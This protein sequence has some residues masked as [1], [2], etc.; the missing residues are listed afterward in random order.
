MSDVI[1]ECGMETEMQSIHPVPSIASTTYSTASSMSR[2]DSVFSTPNT[3]ATQ[4]TNAS[5]ISFTPQYTGSKTPLL[6]LQQALPQSFEDMYSPELMANPNLLIDGRPM[7]TRRALQDWELN[8]IRSLLIIERLRTEWN[9][10]IPIIYSPP[11]FKFDYL[12]LDAD[13]NTVIRVL[14]ESDIYK[15]AKL[16]VAFRIQTAKFT[17]NS[18]RMRHE[19]MLALSGF[20]ISNHPYLSKPEWRNVIE[21]FLLNLA[22]ESQCRSDFKKLCHELKKWKRQQS[23]QPVSMSSSKSVTKGSLLK[24]AILNDVSQSTL[25]PPQQVK[26]T[27]EEKAQ[28]WTEVQEKVYARIGLDWT[29]DRITT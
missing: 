4:Y 15:E 8:D 26:L 23:A 18:A 1:D 27:K 16:D 9:G 21:N 14:V 19:Q 5:D 20:P 10:E 3:L 2:S 24:K 17:L 6:T 12:P 7:F 25:L 22:V 29:P 11:G 13:D 28:L